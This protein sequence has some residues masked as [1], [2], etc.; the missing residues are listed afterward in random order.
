MQDLPP[1]SSANFKV[2][3]DPL[4][5]YQNKIWNWAVAFTHRWN[6]RVACW[7]PGQYCTKAGQFCNSPG[8]F[9]NA[10]RRQHL[11]IQSLTGRK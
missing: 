3:T 9:C 5:E 1:M 8:Q 4:M 10:Q 7:V 2:Q 11:D 6:E